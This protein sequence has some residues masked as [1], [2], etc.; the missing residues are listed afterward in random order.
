MDEFKVS[1]ACN[2]PYGGPL[3]K[4]NWATSSFWPVASMAAVGMRV[5]IMPGVKKP[6]VVDSCG[7]LIGWGQG[8]KRLYGPAPQGQLYD[9][10]AANGTGGLL[11]TTLEDRRTAQAA[12]SV[13][14]HG[15]M[16][17][18][19]PADNPPY[20]A[21][22]LGPAVFSGCSSYTPSTFEGDIAAGCSLSAAVG[23]GRAL[24]TSDSGDV[25]VTADGIELL[26]NGQGVIYKDAALER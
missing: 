21:H 24:Y 19:A 17:S 5:T 3:L 15:S 14:W 11:C 8:G 18:S 13:G 26:A 7:Q 16:G 9:I 6:W 2:R 1:P 25:A 4:W 20:S 22:T 12:C 10:A 23:P